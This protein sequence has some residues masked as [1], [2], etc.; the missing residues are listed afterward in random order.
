MPSSARNTSRAALAIQLYAECQ[1]AG[2]QNSQFIVLITALE[3][4]V[5]GA[6]SKRNAVLG[7]VRDALTAAGHP[8]P[9]AARKALDE[10]YVVRNALLHEAQPVTANQLTSLKTTVR[11]TLK[12]ILA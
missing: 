12:A 4:L 8:N 3:I 7:F 6:G 9:K 2:G 10:L 1:F 11:E 5:P